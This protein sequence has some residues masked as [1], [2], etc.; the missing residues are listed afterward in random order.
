MIFRYTNFSFICACHR[1]S[2][3]SFFYCKRLLENGGYSR[4]PK[5]LP[6]RFMPVLCLTLSLL[7]CYSLHFCLCVHVLLQARKI[8]SC[9]TRYNTTSALVYST[10]RKMRS[11]SRLCNM[12]G[13][14]PTVPIS[15]RMSHP[16]HH[17]HLPLSSG[18]LSSRPLSRQ[19][20]QPPQ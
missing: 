4:R 14:W 10:T 9:N 2:F 18:P 20:L 3:A 1:F 6:K 17:P 19:R 13:T 7:I 5:D 15:C 12:I 8:Q 16:R 11:S